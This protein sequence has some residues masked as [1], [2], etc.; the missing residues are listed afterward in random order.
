MTQSTRLTRSF[1]TAPAAVPD[2]DSARY[3][4]SGLRRDGFESPDWLVPDIE[5]GTAPSLKAAAVQ[6]VIDLVP[7]YESSYSGEVWPRIQW[8]YADADSRDAGIDQIRQLTT[9]VGDLLRGFVI[10]KVGGVS[11]VEE[12][13]SVV[14]DA[15]ADADYPDETF[16]VAL[17]IETARAKSELEAIGRFASDARITALVFGPVDYA[18]EVG[19][20]EIDGERAPWDGFLADLSNAASASGVFA[21]GGPYDRIFTTQAGVTAYDAMG[22]R[23][24]AV[25]EAKLGLDG[26]WS[27][28]PNQTIQA[29][30]V[31]MPT[32]AELEIEVSCTESYIEAK[33]N[34][35]GS[36]LVDGRMVDEGSIR[37]YRNTIKGVAGLHNR[38]PEQTE[39]T[40][41]ESLIDRTTAIADRL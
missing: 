15:E 8:S 38:H 31:H 35:T 18:A 16:E 2:D 12:A 6:N 36:I 26:S 40:Y 24:Q 14:A 29:N 30:H 28:H 10:P 23:E 37:T 27:L 33:N 34:G 17:I 41:P 25:T 3:L 20:R 5:D 22:Y 13:V 7:R 32:P 4:R 11:D 21:F 9:G 1:Q 39:N 19:A